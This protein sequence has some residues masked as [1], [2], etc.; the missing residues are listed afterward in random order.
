MNTG[1]EQILCPNC[2]AGFSADDVRC[3]YCGAL[4]PSGAEEAYMDA[5][6]DIEDE[7]SKLIGTTQGKLLSSLQSSTKRTIA[8][9]I[10]V[11]VVLGGLFAL[12]NCMGAHDERRAIQEYQ[13]R[14]TFR[15]NYFD[16]FDRLYEAGDDD[17]LSNYVWNLID[18]PGF[19]AFYSWEHAGFLEVHDGWETLKSM[20]GDIA[21]GTCGI[22]DYTWAVSLAYRMAGL[23]V[24]GSSLMGTL[25][26]EEEERAADYRAYAREFLRNTLRMNDE[27]V[28]AF[29]KQVTDEDGNIQ[30]DQLKSNLETRF[31]QLGVPY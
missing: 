19:E 18:D 11:V 16:E 28:A 24:N 3:P 20:E 21:A 26:P 13:A 4:N 27:E 7:T 10:L 17:A 5:L 22:D 14:E 8:I 6:E 30:K 29:A 12:F 15:T 25:S 31:K 9:V 2:G 1:S 23:D